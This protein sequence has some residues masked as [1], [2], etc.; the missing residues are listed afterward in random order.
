MTRYANR[1]L[2]GLALVLAAALG[3]AVTAADKEDEKEIKEAQKDILDL[4]KILEGSKVTQAQVTAKVAAIKKKNE[5][6]GPLMHIYKPKN[7]LGLGFG[8]LETSGLESKI[9]DLSKRKLPKLTL[10]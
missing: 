4:V 7:K 6:L 5:D 1:L 3:T 10:E 9:R 2:F 8:E